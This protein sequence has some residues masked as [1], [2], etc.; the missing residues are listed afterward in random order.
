MLFINS[1]RLI[2]YKN[3]AQPHVCSIL[4]LMFG[5]SGVQINSRKIYSDICKTEFNPK[6]ILILTKFSRLEF[7]KLRYS[8]LSDVELEATLKKRGSDYNTL[9]YHHY[10]H[11]V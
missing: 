1:S 6:N 10:I 8:K 5:N 3:I 4:G 9:L 11:K 2:F 7:E